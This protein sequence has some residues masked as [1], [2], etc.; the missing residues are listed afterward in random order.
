M[1]QET[2]FYEPLVA[3]IPTI[4]CQSSGSLHAHMF[5]W[6]QEQVFEEIRTKMT[7]QMP[8]GLAYLTKWHM[9]KTIFRHCPVVTRKRRHFVCEKCLASRR[10]ALHFPRRLQGEFNPNINTT[11]K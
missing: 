8:R 1:A 3:K 7:A 10:C 9:L 6:V 5:Q 11:L 2:L 4:G